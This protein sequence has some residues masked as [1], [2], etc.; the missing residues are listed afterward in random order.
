MIF[1]VKLVFFLSTYFCEFSVSCFYVAKSSFIQVCWNSIGA[2]PCLYWFI[3]LHLLF[4]HFSIYCSDLIYNL[5]ETTIQKMQK[6][7]VINR[8]SC[9]RSKGYKFEKHQ[10]DHSLSVSEK[11]ALLLKLIFSYS[12]FFFLGLVADRGAWMGKKIAPPPSLKLVTHILQRWNLAQLY[13]T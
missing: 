11:V 10:S 5:L 7:K 3:Y 9:L 13:P 12:E 6:L 8:W 2:I 4:I 1:A